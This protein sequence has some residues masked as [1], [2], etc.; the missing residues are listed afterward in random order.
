MCV[1]E[2]RGAPASSDSIVRV[3]EAGRPV[4]GGWV[5]QRVQKL[6]LPSLSPSS[7]V[8]T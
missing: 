6:A 7:R 4:V 1:N 3:L 8:I 2:L 5:D